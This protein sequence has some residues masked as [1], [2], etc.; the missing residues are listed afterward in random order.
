MMPGAAVDGFLF[1]NDITLG[2]NRFAVLQL[3]EA[4]IINEADLAAMFVFDARV[5]ETQIPVALIVFVDHALEPAVIGSVAINARNAA[6]NGGD[7]R[8]LLPVFNAHSSADFH[9]AFVS[10]DRLGRHMRGW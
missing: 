8:R 6:L 7:S 9:G 10:A 3:G 2:E 1:R 5:T 4:R